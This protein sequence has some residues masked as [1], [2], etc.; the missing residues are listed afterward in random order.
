VALA[1]RHINIDERNRRRFRDGDLELFA[2]LFWLKTAA[3]GK[4]LILSFKAAVQFQKPDQD[5][6]GSRQDES[7]CAPATTPG[8][9]MEVPWRGNTHSKSASS[10]LTIWRE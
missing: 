9:K 1:R 2:V 10:T 8:D 5:R 4:V 7:P 6:P 3:L